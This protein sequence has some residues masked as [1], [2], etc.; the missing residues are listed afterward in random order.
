MKSAHATDDDEAPFSRD[1][2]P[3]SAPS[4]RYAIP[5]AAAFKAALA[6]VFAPLPF[7]AAKREPSAAV[8][9]AADVMMGAWRAALKPADDGQGQPRRAE[10]LVLT[11]MRNANIIPILGAKMRADQFEIA[12][13]HRAGR[14]TLRITGPFADIHQMRRVI[15]HASDDLRR[16]GFTPSFSDA[17]AAPRPRGGAT[18]MI[19]FAPKRT[20]SR[21]I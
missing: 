4:S 11:L 10:P 7:K 5:M 3:G 2:G 8:R 6:A 18:A 13:D 21:T 14:T 15:E 12:R 19:V 20:A 9:A 16:A 1:H 17:F